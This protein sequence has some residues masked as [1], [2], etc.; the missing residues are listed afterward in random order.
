MPKINQVRPAHIAAGGGLNMALP[1]GTTS[2]QLETTARW[3][4]AG[5]IVLGMLTWWWPGYHAWG[6]LCFGLLLVWTLWLLARTQIAEARVAGHPLHLV[7]LA[8]AAVLIYHLARTGIGRAAVAPENLA[9][10]L[11]VSMIFQLALL[12][13]GVL[14]AQSLLAPGAPGHAALL[15]VCGA[16]MAGGAAAA[17]VWGRA[18]AACSALSLVGFAGVCVW[19]APVFDRAGAG[20]GAAD[21]GRWRR[22][23]R[24]AAAVLAAAVLACASPYEALLAAGVLGGAAFLAGLILRG[25]RLVL[26]SVGGAVAVAA[27]VVARLTGTML[28]SLEWLPGTWLGVGE[29]AFGRLYAGDSGLAVLSAAVGGLGLF[30]L[31]GGLVGCAVWLLWPA[32]GGGLAAGTPVVVWTAA[33]ALTACALLAPAGPFIPAVALAVAL[34]WGVAPSVGGRRVRR[35]PAAAMLVPMGGLMLLLGLA[36]RD[37]LVLWAA[38]AWGAGGGALHLVTGFVLALALGWA[39]GTRR[40]WLGLVG[41][42]AAAAAGAAG[43]LAQAVASDRS[44]QLADW[45]A[46]AAGAAVAV[47]L[48]LLAVGARWCESPEARPLESAAYTAP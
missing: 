9:G 16:A 30:A 36:R 46:H 38:E 2:R 40:V 23:T 29:T 12:S 19:L 37:G 42:A 10:A 47:P 14:L 34:T 45:L 32:R 4:L 35:H 15:S 6:G 7:L 43:E 28:L 27:A 8:P 5:L 18:Q 31:I 20:P 39:C 11:N 26:L 3:A 17:M 22:L 41:I 24:L 33:A 13:L 21:R 44:V 25:R 48:Y 1:V